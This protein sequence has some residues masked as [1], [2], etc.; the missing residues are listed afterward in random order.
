[1]ITKKVTKFYHGLLSLF[2]MAVFIFGG[3]VYYGVEPQIPLMF[4]CAVACVVAVWIGYKWEEILSAIIEGV[5]SALEA[6]LVLMLIGVL[7]GAWI[8]SGTVPTLIYYGLNLISARFFLVSAAL[9]CGI[10]SFALGAWGTVGT[11]GLAFMGIGIALKIPSPLVAG[12]II[13][14]SYLGEIISPVSD[15]TNLTAAVT[16]CNIFDLMRKSMPLSMLAFAI[17]EVLY[18]ILGMEYSQSGRTVEMSI[19]PFFEALEQGVR[20]TPANLLP[21]LV[22]VLCVSRKIPAIPTMFAGV[23]AGLGVGVLVQGQSPGDMLTVCLSGYVSHTGNAEID[24]LLTNGG[25]NSMLHSITIVIIA[26]AFGGIMQGTGQMS[27][28]MAPVI[29]RIH[30]RGQL[31]LATVLSCIGMNIVLPDQY[32]GISVP[33]QMYVKEFDRHGI[34]RGCF[35]KVLLCGGAVTSPVV[36]WNTCGIYCMSILG[37][38]ATEYIMYAFLCLLLPVMVVLAEALGGMRKRWA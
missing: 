17:S 19:A 3:I 29:R 32:L 13:S 27:A 33:C 36:P 6:V 31:A 12:A 24:G 14:G 20:I 5:S 15:A 30:G 21:A 16:Q 8:A 1:M 10:V 38:S 9:T 37:V 23:V 25:M 28:L 35:S 26:M 22:L 7:V 4:G 18:F 2:A 34:S 11:M